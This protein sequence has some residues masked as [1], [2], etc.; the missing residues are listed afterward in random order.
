MCLASVDYI[1][2][3]D[4]TNKT[5]NLS[6]FGKLNWQDLAKGGVMV[7]IFAILTYL[8]KLGVSTGNPTIDGFVGL[9]ITYLLKQLATDNN[10]KL[11]GKI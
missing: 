1:N 9:L 7:V 5:M 2:I 8:N 10:G 11:M 4:L 3:K 6:P